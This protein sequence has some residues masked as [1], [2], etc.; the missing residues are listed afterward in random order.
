MQHNEK[1]NN[2]NKNNTDACSED[3]ESMGENMFGISI[4]FLYFSENTYIKTT[5]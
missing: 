4:I 5:A 2:G 1:C 3:T